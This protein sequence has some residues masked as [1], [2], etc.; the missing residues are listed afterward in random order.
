MLEVGDAALRTGA[1]AGGAETRARAR[2]AYLLAFT[3]AR[4]E[5]AVDGVLRA[6]QAFDDLGDRDAATQCLHV[7]ERMRTMTF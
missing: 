5:G 6:A 3:R 4:Q 1:A 2:Q 7:A